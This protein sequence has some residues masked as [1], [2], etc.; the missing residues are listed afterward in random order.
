MNIPAGLKYTRTY[1][2]AKQEH[3][4]T[5]TVGITHH[6]QDLLGDVGPDPGEV[7]AVN[8]GLENAQEKSMRTY[9]RRFKIRPANPAEF[10]ALLGPDE[11]Q[12]LAELGN[13]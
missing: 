4:G 11:Y 5:V 12:K 2:W 9:M 8:H 1:E 6:A 13:N 10:N 7:I 3:G